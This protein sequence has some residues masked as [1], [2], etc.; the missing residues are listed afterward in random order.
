MPIETVRK[1]AGKSVK[2]AR[3]EAPY[4]AHYKFSDAE[5]TYFSNQE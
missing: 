5:V 2:D 3:T 4:I 1:I